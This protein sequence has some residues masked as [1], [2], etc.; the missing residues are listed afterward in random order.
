[1]LFFAVSLGL[2]ALESYI[3]EICRRQLQQIYS[4]AL[5][6]A[7]RDIC[8]WKACLKLIDDAAL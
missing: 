3:Q 4:T 1:M 8:W 5:K 7:M 6:A 2:Q